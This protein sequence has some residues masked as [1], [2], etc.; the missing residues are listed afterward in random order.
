MTA[1]ELEDGTPGVVLAD[2]LEE[3]EAEPWTAL[4]PALDP[5]AMGWKRRGFYLGEHAERVFD[6]VDD[7]L[8]ES[9]EGG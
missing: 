4:R 3:V 7:Y 6:A 1:C 2:D 9:R 5:T 8:K